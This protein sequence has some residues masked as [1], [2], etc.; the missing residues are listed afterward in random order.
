MFK[1]IIVFF[2]F[3][4]ANISF[5]QECVDDYPIIEEASCAINAGQSLSI[6]QACG[7]GIYDGVV[8]DNVETAKSIG[9]FFKSLTIKDICYMMPVTAPFALAYDTNRLLENKEAVEAIRKIM[10]L[11][12][13]YDFQGLKELIYSYLEPMI[14]K[15]KGQYQYLKQEVMEAFEG[16]F[17]LINDPD[18]ASHAAELT[19]NFLTSTGIGSLITLFTAGAG[20]SLLAFNLLKSAHNVRRVVGRVSKF[21][22]KSQ[23]IGALKCGI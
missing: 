19:C 9:A 5:S 23:K 22:T 7:K 11:L 16:L 17:K 15:V 1:P 10:H 21:K 3:I 13:S 4:I 14:E 2:Y 20:A 12:F 8:T 6:I 18:L